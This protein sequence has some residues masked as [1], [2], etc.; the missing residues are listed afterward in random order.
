[1]MSDE[2][3]NAFQATAWGEGEDGTVRTGDPVVD[4]WER[5]LA[6]EDELD[7]HWAETVKKGLGM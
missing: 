3:W 4:Q 6:Q 5:E 7:P 2:D 1:M